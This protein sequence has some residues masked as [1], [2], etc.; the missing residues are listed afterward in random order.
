MMYRPF[1][2]VVL[3]PESYKGEISKKQILFNGYMELLYLH[4]NHFTPDESVLKLLGVEEEEKFVLLRF[5]SWQAT[6]DSG[7]SGLNL[8]NKRKAVKEFSK[9]ARVFISSE[10][11]L[12]EDLEPYRISIPPA[13]MHDVLNYA[14]LFFGESATMASESAVLGTPAIYLDNDGR[15]YTDDLEKS[16]GLVYNFT[17]SPSDQQKSIEMGTKLLQYELLAE[18]TLK[19]KNL[20]LGEKI[21]LTAYLVKFVENKFNLHKNTSES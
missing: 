3:S 12:P 11:E 20:L 2:D 1:T 15:G 9:Y 14:L 16:Y 10:A 17:V 19:K 21:D 13:K 4:P 5:V 7:H 18:K 8:E 6:H